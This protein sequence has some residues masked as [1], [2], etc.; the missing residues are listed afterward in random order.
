MWYSPPVR[1]VADELRRLDHEVE[2][3]LTPSERV[4]RA[5]T[6]GD[7]DVAIFAAAQ[8]L[9]PETAR[10]RIREIRSHGRIRSVSAEE[11]RA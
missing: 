9:D 4:L 8:G 3:A 11:P 6:L 10:R 2:R 1:S 7:Q 5:L